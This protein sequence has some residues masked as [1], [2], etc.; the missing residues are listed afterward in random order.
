MHRSQREF[1]QVQRNGRF[2]AA[3]AI[4]AD[5]VG[6]IVRRAVRDRR[7]RDALEE[8]WVRCA[9]AAWAGR[10]VLGEFRAGVLTVEVSGAALCAELA[11]RASLLA[12]S[13]AL[14]LPALKR[15]VFVCAGTGRVRPADEA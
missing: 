10:C 9:D 4:T 7:R 13:L 14:S 2:R 5:G 1:E 8:A 12:R 3:Q 6:R 11:G 15:V